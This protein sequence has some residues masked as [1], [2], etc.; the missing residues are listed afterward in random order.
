MPRAFVTAVLGALALLPGIAGAAPAARAPVAILGL[1]VANAHGAKVQAHGRGGVV[2]VKVRAGA[3]THARIALDGR[4]RTRLR[5]VPFLARVSV[6]GLSPGAHAIVIRTRGAWLARITFAVRRLAPVIKVVAAPRAKTDSRAARFAWRTTPAVARTTC[7]LDGG[8]ARRCTSPRRYARLRVGAHRLAITVTARG[9]MT[10]TLLRS[11]IVSLAPVVTFTARPARTT[12]STRARL[13]WR[14]S[15]RVVRT[16]CRLDGRAF[17]T[18]KAPVVL[19]ALAAGPHAFD[20][21]VTSRR[22]GHTGTGRA[23]WVVTHAAA[24]TTTVPGTVARPPGGAVASAPGAPFAAGASAGNFQFGVDKCQPTTAA[25]LAKVRYLLRFV[26][27]HTGVLSSLSLQFIA[28]PGSPSNCPTGPTGYGGGTSGIALISTYGVNADGTPN[29]AQLLSRTQLVPCQA[30]TGGS[31]DV[32]LGLAVTKGQELATV[33]Q[34]VDS[35]PVTNFFS[36]NQLYDPLG[37]A[38]ANGR[39]ERSATAT[40]AYY[41]LDPRELVG[42]SVDG[43]ATWR[44]PEP[45]LVPTYVQAYADGY[46]DGQP[47]LYGTCPCPGA[48]S[49]TATMVFPHVPVDWTITSVG[50]YTLAPGSSRVDLLVNDQVVASATLSGTGMLRA[51]IA[52]VTAPAGSTVKV[53]ATAGGGGLALTRVD[54]DTTWKLGPVLTLGTGWRWYYEEGQGGGASTAAAIGLYPLPMYPTG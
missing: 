13:A 36:V 16:R 35:D 15:G 28:S 6:T 3:R 4:S 48:I 10:T 25:C 9:G 12:T 22:T 38:G 20:V 30:A 50:A 40:D 39:N 54:A 31:V 11:W 5:A 49:G 32:P 27:R 8:R 23:T 2:W 52:P 26:A 18:C 34:N 24:P 45:H 41:G 7:R 43:G 46:R 29:T 44:L 21:R 19:T 37:L 47:Y 1:Q 53:R 33:I 17:T 14:T 42:S 51:A